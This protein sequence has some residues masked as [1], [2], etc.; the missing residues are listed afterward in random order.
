MFLT[1]FARRAKTLDDGIDVVQ[2]AP[3]DLAAVNTQLPIDRQTACQRASK[4]MSQDRLE[5]LQRLGVEIRS[6]ATL[7]ALQTLAAR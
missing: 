7:R 6:A 2:G 4:A 1:L 5:I 3:L